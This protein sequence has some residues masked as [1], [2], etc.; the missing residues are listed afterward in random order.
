MFATPSPKAGGPRLSHA[1]RITREAARQGKDGARRVEFGADIGK[2][3]AG[4]VAGLD[5]PTQLEAVQWIRERG[6]KVLILIS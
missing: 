4:E 5:T 2:L 6:N 1:Q 3:R